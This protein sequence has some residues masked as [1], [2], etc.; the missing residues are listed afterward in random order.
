[1]IFFIISYLVLILSIYMCYN[2]NNNND[3]YLNLETN[4]GLFYFPIYSQ[5]HSFIIFIQ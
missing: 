1:M 3:V 5:E 4:K 2:N